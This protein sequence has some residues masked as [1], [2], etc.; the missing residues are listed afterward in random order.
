[1]R[2]RPW[3][4]WAFAAWSAAT[5][6]GDESEP[7]RAESASA[8][9]DFSR[10]DAALEAAIAEYNGGAAEDKRIHGASAVIVHDKLGALHS[11]GYGDYAADRLYLI[12]SSSKIL[13]VGV[14][15]RLADQGKLDIDAPIGT[16]LSDWGQTQASSISVA[17]LVSNSSGLPSLAEVSA[18]ANDPKSP[19]LSNLCQY[20]DAGKLQDCGKT[21][22]AT[23]PPRKPDSMFAYG[24]S[25]WQLAG[26]IAE[27]VSGKHWAELID[28]TYVSACDVPSL[29]YT[30]Q[31]A[32]GGTSY[33]TFFMADEANLPVTE[34]PSIEGGAYVTAPD[35]GKLLLMHLRNG[36]CDDKRVLSQ[37][38]TERMR[39]NRLKAYGGTT[40]NAAQPGYGLGFWTDGSER[41]VTDAG[42]YGAYPL[43]DLDRHYGMFIVIELSSEVGVRLGNKVKPVLDSIFDQAKL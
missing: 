24:G 14:L 34:N 15:M 41:V 28:E 31:F 37:A 18:A 9:L 11:R 27:R 33:P 35:Y 7:S 12:A 40:G 32:R 1:M 3:C 13:S 20:N 30:N 17:Q 38:A 19:F 29:G 26:A 21:L 36:V 39:K 42:A 8:Q 10:F 2:V 43:L 23:E 6:C 5:G 22:Y 25:Q 16:Y 4:A